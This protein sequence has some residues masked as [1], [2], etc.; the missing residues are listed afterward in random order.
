MNHA[1]RRLIIAAAALAAAA[2]S[3]IAPRFALSEQPTWTTLL[4]NTYVIRR[5]YS[6]EPAE[7]DTSGIWAL[8]PVTGTYQR[9]RPFVYNARTSGIADD[10]GWD[11]TGSYLASAGDRLIFEGWPSVIEFDAAS[12]RLLRRFPATDP[13]LGYDGWVI[14]GPLID[15]TMASSIGLSAGYY[16]F[17]HCLYNLVTLGGGWGPP[18]PCQ[19]TLFPGYDSP[20]SYGSNEVFLRGSSEGS[21][22]LVALAT[23]PPYSA[24]Q[25]GAIPGLVSLDPGRGGFWLG[26]KQSLGFRP[27]INGDIGD[28]TVTFDLTGEPLNHPKLA[29]MA[30]LYHP[31][32]G[33]FILKWQDQEEGSYYHVSVLD[34]AF[35]LLA[36]HEN[37]GATDLRFPKTFAAFAGDPPSE[38][39]RTIPIVVHT[40]GKNGTFW[41]SDLYL[42]NPSSEP[43]I[44]SVRR[45]TK[46]AETRAV[47]LPA[48]GSAAIPDALAWAGGGPSGDGVKHDALVL[49]S[50]YRWGENLVAAA[51][52]WTP[53]SDPELRAAGGTMGQA[54]PAVPDIVGYSNHLAWDNNEEEASTGV[55]QNQH[56]FIRNAVLILDHRTPGRFRHNMGVV[57]D[58]DQPLTI[59]LTWASTWDF[60]RDEGASSRRSFDPRRRRHLRRHVAAVPA[61]R[62]AGAAL[63]RPGGQRRLPD[64][65]RPLQRRRRPRH[66]QPPYAV[67]RRRNQGR[68]EGD[69]PSALGQS[70]R[71]AGKPPR[72]GQRLARRWNLRPHRAPPG[73]P[74]QRRRGPVLGVR[75]LSRQRDGRLDEL[76]VRGGSEKLGVRS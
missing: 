9:L 48:Y 13:A 60:L 10:F 37:G 72:P 64:Q 41:T 50:P 35:N 15:R 21:D 71:V 47:N 67:L 54:V 8:D 12:L 66:R 68:R 36:D 14:Q 69:N 31:F 19:P 59:R 51:R 55:Y 53:D 61:A 73:R 45:V 46:P 57:N 29:L 75:F 18:R 76:V 17:I 52:V 56:P 33:R 20:I 44:V 62:L 26:R 25:P 6:Y 32:T 39:T 22:A 16:G 34:D 70:G 7:A 30:F 38:Y 4:T 58:E 23:V 74:G 65:R 49:T 40:A 63:R 3:L 2:P 42:Y 28:E 11:G 27:I 24:T 1:P 5:H 43:M